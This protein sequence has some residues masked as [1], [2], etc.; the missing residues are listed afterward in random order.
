MTY[1]QISVFILFVKLEDMCKNCV[2]D[3]LYLVHLTSRHPS[4][5]PYSKMGNTWQ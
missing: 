4:G 1:L 5:Y 2:C 3:M